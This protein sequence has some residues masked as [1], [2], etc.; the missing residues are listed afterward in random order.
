MA[1]SAAAA[2]ID[3]DLAQKPLALPRELRAGAHDALL[4]AALLEAAGPAMELLL[5]TGEAQGITEMRMFRQ[6]QINATIVRWALKAG[7]MQWQIAM[8]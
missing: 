6:L 7:P 2:R 3:D 8:S 1:K 5:A 4:A